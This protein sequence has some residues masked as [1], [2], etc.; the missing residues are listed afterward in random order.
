MIELKGIHRAYPYALIFPT[1]LIIGL[2]LL[3]PMFTGLL[4]SFQNYILTKPVPANERFIGLTNFI[5]IF[6][7]PLFRFSIAKT[8]QWVFFCV[9]FQV[10]IGLVAALVLNQNF[11]FRALVRGFVLIPWVIPGVVA[12]LLWS[13]IMDG[14][15]GLFNDILKRL[16]LIEQNIPWLSNPKTAFGVVIAANVWKGFPF[17]AISILAGLQAVPS[18]LYE[19]AEIDGAGAWRRF[20]TV[21]LPHLK[22][23]LITT[24]I[25]R[26]IWTANNTTMIF[27]M[28]KGGPGYTTHVLALYSY[29]T[30]WGQL[31]FGYSSAMAI[32]LMIIMLIIISIYMRLVDKGKEAGI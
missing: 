25:L 22:P 15:Y 3:Y 2:I 14:T 4:L 9:S 17:F 19:A 29:M 11:P 7:D 32:I 8:A 23:V 16:Y 12:G 6:K 26:L 28:T 27:T 18:D 21:T 13:W 24:T 30:A 20:F 1:L 10:L 31:D 5:N